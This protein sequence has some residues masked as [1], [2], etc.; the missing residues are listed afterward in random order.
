MRLIV[1]DDLLPSPSTIGI[2]IPESS[3][4]S[5]PLDFKVIESKVT[6]TETTESEGA[7]ETEKETIAV[8][9][10]VSDGKMVLGYHYCCHHKMLNLNNR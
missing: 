9:G 6:L 8:V 1:N 3:S 5:S 4:A 10:A 7:S 2:L